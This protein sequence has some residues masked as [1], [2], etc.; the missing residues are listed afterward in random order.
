MIGEFCH[1]NKSLTLHH[2]PVFTYFT[3]LINA[4][5]NGIIMSLALIIQSGRRFLGTN[6]GSLW[7]WCCLAQAGALG[8]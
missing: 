2:K 6:G 7:L 8:P 3:D 1:I 5:L 4:K